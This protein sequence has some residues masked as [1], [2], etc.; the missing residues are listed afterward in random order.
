V[1]LS[2]IGAG[3]SDVRRGI[4]GLPR[5]LM[6]GLLA[7]ALAAVGMGIV[8]SGGFFA[9]TVGEQTAEAVMGAAATGWWTAAPLA[10]GLG[11]AVWLAVRHGLGR[12]GSASFGAALSAIGAVWLD[13]VFALPFGAAALLARLHPLLALIPAVYLL[14][15]SALRQFTFH[16]LAPPLAWGLVWLLAWPAVVRVTRPKSRTG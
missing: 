10:V 3:L 4:S 16:G 11:A 6:V 1:V 5:Q 12:E 8:T 9:P 13:P 7:A 2:G 14:R 15:P